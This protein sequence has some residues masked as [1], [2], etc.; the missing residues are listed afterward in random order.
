MDIYRFKQIIKYSRDNRQYIE[1]NVKN[2]YERINMSSEK[3]LL[4]LMQIVRPLFTENSYL[5]LEIP[6]SDK[7]IGALSYTGDALGYTV[8]NT[9]LPKVNVNFAL[10]HEIYHIFYQKSVYR[11]K[12]ELVNE[13]YYECEEE[14]AANLFAGMLLMP[15]SSFKFMYHKFETEDTNISDKMSILVKL[16][17]YFEVPY[18]AAL[19]RCYELDLL[20][21]GE[22]LEKLI[23]INNEMIK[24]K[25]AELW[26]D[27]TIL[28][29]S[30]KDDYL[31]L[32]EF[33]T[34]LG[35]KFVQENYL[36]ER[37]LKQVLR[38]MRTLYDSIK[39]E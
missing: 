8:L 7:E 35:N 38:N 15:E 11:Q 26:L 36:N 27:D 25:F 33:V 12:V 22:L 16:M 1:A 20:E 10:C 39:G 28:N 6:F 14:F 4:N 2:F 23:N 19:I 30:Q 34:E 5:I 3:S 24:N 18:M 17:S 13:H 32:E 31:R 21:A 37:N 29:A 9:S